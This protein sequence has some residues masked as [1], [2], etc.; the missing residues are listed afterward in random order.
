MFFGETAAGA[1][2]KGAAIAGGINVSGKRA[3]T[4]P[5]SIPSIRGFRKKT[6]QILSQAAKKRDQRNNRSGSRT[7]A[8]EIPP[9]H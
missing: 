1:A 3:E 9:F 7:V 5:L 8:N 4:V 6:N 2:K